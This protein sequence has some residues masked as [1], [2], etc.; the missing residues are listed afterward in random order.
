MMQLFYAILLSISSLNAQISRHD[1]FLER[2]YNKIIQNE[3]T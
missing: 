2:T 1:E 3:Y